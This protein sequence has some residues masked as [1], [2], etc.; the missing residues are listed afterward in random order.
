MKKCI[1][2]FLLMLIKIQSMTAI[3]SNDKRLTRIHGSWFIQK[4]TRMKHKL[5]GIQIL[6][7]QYA[8]CPI[9]SPA[10]NECSFPKD[11]GEN[12][13]TEIGWIQRD[14]NRQTKP[15]IILVIRDW[16]SA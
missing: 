11:L 16:N 4:P 13:E 15:E 3:C 8:F 7:N 9:S 10:G 5:M 2:P 12:N 6:S 1:V 14:K